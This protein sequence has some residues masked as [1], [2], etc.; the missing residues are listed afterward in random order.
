M[1][2]IYGEG[3][4]KAFIRLHREI[5]LSSAAADSTRMMGKTRVDRPTNS[6]DNNY[7]SGFQFNAHGGV[8]NNNTGSGAQ[9]FGNFSGPVNFG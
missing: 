9:F 3:R 2:L 5:E 7:G 4:Q 1:P 6:Y 8:Q